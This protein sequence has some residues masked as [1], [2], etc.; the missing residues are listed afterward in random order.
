MNPRAWNARALGLAVLV[1]A[2]LAPGC[3]GGSGGSDSSTVKGN[4]SS[5]PSASIGRERRSW[6]AWVGEEAF[7]LGRRAFA[8]TGLGGVQVQVSS[9]NATDS[10]TTDDQGDFDV[11]SPTG[12]VTVTFNRGSCH[13]VV[14]L[15]DMT[16]NA[17][18]TLQDV[19]FTCGS[20]QPAKVEETFQGV[21]RHV[22][23][24]ANGNLSVCVTSGG[25]G[26]TRIVKLKDATI[27]SANGFAD[28][29]VGQLVEA[30]GQRE[31]LGTSSALDAD[32]VK[33]L[34]SGNSDDCSGQPTPTPNETSTP[35]PTTTGTPTE[36]ETPTPTP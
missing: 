12:D 36:T 17:T 21:V 34:G 14:A 35:E 18:V 33:I 25:G 22:P 32:T 9:V 10:G 15:P 1:F 2:A 13:G 4:L 3:G 24:S 5:A 19:D 28:L 8:V 7:G 20:A 29:A 31:G 30:A 26:R 11:S 6:L 27:E 23:G 16:R